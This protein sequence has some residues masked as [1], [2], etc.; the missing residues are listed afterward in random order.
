ME[1]LEKNVKYEYDKV[2]EKEYSWSIRHY[3]DI[4]TCGLHSNER[5]ATVESFMRI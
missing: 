3:K 2:W 5:S 1:P 4:F